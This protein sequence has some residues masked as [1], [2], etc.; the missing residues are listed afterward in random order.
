MINYRLLLRIIGQLLFIEAG[1]LMTCLLVSLAYGEDDSFSFLTATLT[2]TLAG[3]LARFAGRNSDNNLSRRDAYL[4]VTAA[5]GI[6]SVFGTLPYLIGGYIPDVTNAY[7]ETMSGFTTTGA[8]ILDDVEH[9]PHAILFW[10]SMTQWIGG[11]GIVFF[12]IAL[13]PSLVGSGS[14]KVFSAETTGPIHTK[15]HPRLSTSAHFI[16]MIYIILTLVCALCYY[17]GG[18]SAFDCI[19]YSM[20]TLATGGFAT[21][22]SSTEFFN[23]PFIEY[24]A[25]LF[26]FLAGINFLLLY[27]TI[28]KRQIGDFF[29]NSEIRLYIGA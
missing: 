16:W 12:T 10:R 1:F 19:N 15:M 21:H 20:T 3:L 4:V 5:W 6:F 27:A 23:S 28:I 7:F 9:L 2:T 13:L 8:S 11:L 26:C 25:T 24:T 29:R 14:V 18:M 22:N 17:I